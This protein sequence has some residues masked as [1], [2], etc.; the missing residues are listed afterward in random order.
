MTSHI[1]NAICKKILITYGDCDKFTFFNV[2]DVIRDTSLLKEFGFGYLGRGATR[3]A[4]GNLHYVI[5]IGDPNNNVKELEASMVLDK[6]PILKY[7]KVPVFKH[8]E[9]SDHL[10]INIT[11]RCREPK[12]SN[13]S[14][15]NKA[16][17][18]RNIMSSFYSDVGYANVG[19]FGKSL[20][21]LDL[22]YPYVAEPDHYYVS[23]YKSLINFDAH[24]KTYDAKVNRL[25]LVA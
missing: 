2:P 16:D 18:I 22:N 5:K 10:S 8:I 3:I 20:V 9:L 12:W 4:F 11:A 23:E 15:D 19:M 24:K 17:K 7:T 13:T 1:I 14:R 25:K 21:M 6:H